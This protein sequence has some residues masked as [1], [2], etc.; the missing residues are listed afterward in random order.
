[1]GRSWVR[2]Q[3]VLEDRR[4]KSEGRSDAAGPALVIIRRLQR[5]GVGGELAQAGPGVL[6]ATAQ[7]ARNAGFALLAAEGG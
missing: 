3:V 4:S 1:M 7:F 5:P 2:L 6:A